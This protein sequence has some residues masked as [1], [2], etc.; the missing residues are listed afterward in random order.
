MAM[1]CKHIVPLKAD[2]ACT[3]IQ[4]ASLATIVANRGMYE[5]TKRGSVLF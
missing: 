2:H 3:R 1:A 4:L 5:S